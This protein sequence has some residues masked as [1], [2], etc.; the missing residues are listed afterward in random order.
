MLQAL[1]MVSKIT[2]EN[3]II[4]DFT[5]NLI[6]DEEQLIEHQSF[7]SKFTSLPCIQQIF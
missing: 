7:K 5:M 6:Y 3:L 1:C 2:K 4:I